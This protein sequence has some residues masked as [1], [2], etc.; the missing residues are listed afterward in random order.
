MHMHE[1]QLPLQAQR[2]VEQAGESMARAEMMQRDAVREEAKQPCEQRERVGTRQRLGAECVLSEQADAH[3][4]LHCNA[5]SSKDE[6]AGSVKLEDT[7]GI[8][9]VGMARAAEAEL[10]SRKIESS[11]RRA[12]C[13]IAL[14]R[15][16]SQ[17][18]GRDE[19]TSRR[20]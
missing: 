11:S 10:E 9:E 6:D 18:T 2:M 16:Q 1:A 19:R 20:A 8:R 15:G 12:G 17:H 5:R 13:A 3:T 4:Q 14:A 7:H